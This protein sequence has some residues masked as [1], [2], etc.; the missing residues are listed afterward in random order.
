[1]G[2]DEEQGI[3]GGELKDPP[4]TKVAKQYKKYEASMR[5]FAIDFEKLRRRLNEVDILDE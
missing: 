4:S 2:K 5:E 3:W 1:L